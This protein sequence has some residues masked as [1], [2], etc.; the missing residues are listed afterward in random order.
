MYSLRRWWDRHRT[1]LVLASLALGT[2]VFL[3]QTGGGIIYEVYRLLAQPFHA[4]SRSDLVL[5]DARLQEYQQRLEELESQNQQLKELLEFKGKIPKQGITAQVIGRSADHWWQQL[6]LGR[7]RSDGVQ[8]GDVVMAP[9]GLVGRVFEVTQGTSRV[10]LLSDPSSRVGVTI[11]RSRFMG[12]MRGTSANRAVM[13]FFDKVPDVQRGD[14]IVTSGFSCLFPAGLPIGRVES[15]D[16][17]KSPAPEA[18]ITLSSPVSSLEW[19]MIYPRS[20]SQSS[21]ASC[22]ATVSPRSPG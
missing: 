3:Q 18:V 10:L 12:Y 16:L 17:S 7:G 20:Q 6:L 2:G 21:E 8:V 22:D 13:E 1:F 9:G 19:A 5:Q 14:M 15:V 11:S 4:G